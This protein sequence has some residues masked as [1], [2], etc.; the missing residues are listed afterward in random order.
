MW[1][2]VTGDEVDIDVSV[3]LFLNQIILRWCRVVCV[4]ILHMPPY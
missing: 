4:T 2:Y 1:Y 3:A